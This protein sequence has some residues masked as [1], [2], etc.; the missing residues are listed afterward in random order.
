MPLASSLTRTEARPATIVDLPHPFVTD[1][2]P[3]AWT[4]LTVST[5]AAVVAAVAGAALASGSE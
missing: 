4:E 3:V 1:S 2:M 5:R